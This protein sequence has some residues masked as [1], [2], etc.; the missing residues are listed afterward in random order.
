MTKRV[1]RMPGEAIRW[2]SRPRIRSVLLP[3]PDGTGASEGFQRH[4]PLTHRLDPGPQIRQPLLACD[5]D[6]SAG[7]VRRRQWYQLDPGRSRRCPMAEG[8]PAC[9]T[10]GLP[11]ALAHSV[12]GPITPVRQVR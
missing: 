10:A 11:G 1:G 4:V 2:R 7:V 5:G 8:P 6:R 12:A 9:Q 3:G